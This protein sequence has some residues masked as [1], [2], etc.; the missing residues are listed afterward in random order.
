[1]LVEM[2]L[3]EALE[4]KLAT[5]REI[6]DQPERYLSQF[7]AALRKEIVRQT[8]VMLCDQLYE[9]PPSSHRLPWS[10]HERIVHI[11][12]YFYAGL[13][14]I[15]SDLV[16]RI[17]LRQIEWSSYHARLAEL[18]KL[19]EH[20][21]PDSGVDMDN[22]FLP[23]IRDRAKYEHDSL[24]EQLEAEMERVKREL[25]H[26]KT[27]FFERAPRNGFGVLVIFD[28]PSLDRHEIDYLR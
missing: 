2:S 23:R 5:L 27:I 4:Q 12:K 25:F 13:Q 21:Q 26:S 20:Y 7:F 6:N 9:R 14:K 18:A 17:K 3:K 1:M 10:E 8:E 19:V 15:E 11:R 16:A 24:D 22:A 28:S